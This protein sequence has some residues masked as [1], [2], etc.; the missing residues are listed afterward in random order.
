VWTSDGMI[1]LKWLLEIEIVRVRTNSGPCPIVG[2][3]IMMF[4]L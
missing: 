3:G 4:N 1:I 2:F